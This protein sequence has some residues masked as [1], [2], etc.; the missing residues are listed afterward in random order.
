MEQKV[1]DADSLADRRVAETQRLAALD[2]AE[3]DRTEA[4]ANLAAAIDAQEQSR[5]RLDRA[6]REW[7]DSWPLAV[8]RESDLGRLKALSTERAAILE[9]AEMAA[10]MLVEAE[11]LATE[12]DPKTEMLQSAEERLGISQQRNESL[13]ARVRSVV[14]LITAHDDAYADYRRDVAAVS[15]S[16]IRLATRRENLSNLTSAFAAWRAEWTLALAA[17]GL[18][19]E[20]S[21]A[22][23]NEVVTQWAAAGGV[24][25]GR[26]VTS[27]RL[28]RMDDDERDL[29]EAVAKIVGVL[30][31]SLPADSVAAAKMLEQRWAAANEIAIRRK[32]LEPQL[33]QQT[34]DCDRKRTT[35]NDAEVALTVLCAEAG[36]QKQQLRTIAARCDER[37]DLARRRQQLIGTIGTAA[38]GYAL[39]AL[40]E[41]RCERDLDVI[42]AELARVEEELQRV[43]RSREAAAV[44]AESAKQ[45]VDRFMTS[46]GI[47]QAVAGRE[48]ATTA[49]QHVVERYVELSLAGEFLSAAINQI[50]GEQQDPLV[51]RAGELFALSSNGAFLAV[52]SDIDEKGR[53]IVVGK[54]ST[55]ESVRVGEMSDGTRDQLFLAFRLASLEHYCASSEP[56]PLIC[57]DLLVHFDDDRSSATLDLLAEIG[58]TTQVLLFTHHRKVV[59]GAAILVERGTASV[60]DLSAAPPTLP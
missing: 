17:V 30:D 52:D 15:D 19:K 54:R 55:G 43:D 22:R 6:K 44:A 36:C 31:F 49:M 50:R 4:V 18:E 53:P 45:D 24:L 47:N 48:S 10:S 7:T 40:R 9:R 12:T 29:D 26:D 60:F 41:Q 28:R 34:K 2:L 37:A 51:I 21:P 27:R 33:V 23:G 57:D 56:L 59:E 8:Q 20:V 13:A 32:S 46:E 35:L 39:D 42:A 38:D 1:D 16:S 5:L 11:L 3:R 14:Q 58:K 25:D